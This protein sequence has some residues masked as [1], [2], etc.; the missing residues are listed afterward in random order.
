MLL[1]KLWW[2]LAV[3]GVSVR[4]LKLTA[5]EDKVSVNVRQNASLHWTFHINKGETY[6]I[7]WATSTVDASGTPRM[8]DVLFS[9]T[10]KQATATPSSKMPPRYARRVKILPP[11]T[12]FIQRVDLSDEGFYICEI[13]TAFRA[14]RK[15]INLTVIG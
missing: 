8:K 9:K 2:F 15:A 4:A 6:R 11:A 3:S 7:L 14:I 10:E 12:L 1:C 5:A 13:T